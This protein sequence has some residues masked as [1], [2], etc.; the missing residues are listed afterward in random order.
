MEIIWLGHACFRL[1]GKEA[2]VVT[3]PYDKSVGYALGKPSADIVTLSHSHP[4]HGNRAGVGGEPRIVD[5]PGEYE[6]KGV[7]IT[8]FRTD[9]D[10]EGGKARGK[11]TAYLIEMESLAIGHLGDLGHVLTAAQVEA[12]SK[13]DVLLVPVGGVTTINAAQAAEVI[14]LIE[15][16]IVVPMH[17]RA[18]GA[19]AN[20]DP[21]DRFCREMGAASLTP[22]PRLSVTQSN[23]PDITQVVLLE[24]RRG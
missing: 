3:D 22:Q 4:G 12:M 7:V 6:I 9:H 16:K 5:G 10:S 24:Q 19:D 21:V 17:Y 13:V 15:P 20:L 23:L 18:A 11:N 8:G 1:R 14:S 2:V